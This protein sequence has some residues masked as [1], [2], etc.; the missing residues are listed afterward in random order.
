MF[1]SLSHH[2]PLC[3]HLG[4]S[5]LLRLLRFIC[6]VLAQLDPVNE[7]EEE[8]ISGPGSSRDPAGWANFL[9]GDLLPLFPNLLNSLALF[10]RISVVCVSTYFRASVLQPSNDTGK[11]QHF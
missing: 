5:V 7:G 8:A 9:S 10:S 2:P 6:S 3:E 1:P 11:C 4:G